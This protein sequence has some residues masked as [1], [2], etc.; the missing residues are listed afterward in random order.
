MLF[1]Y[2][3][4]HL[5]NHPELQSRRFLL[6]YHLIDSKVLNHQPINLLPNLPQNQVQLSRTQ[7][8][9]NPL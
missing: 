8:L 9:P 7:N 1:D 4:L 2:F 6:A 3:V 5:E